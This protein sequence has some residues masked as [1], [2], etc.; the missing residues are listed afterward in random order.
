VDNGQGGRRVFWMSVYVIC[1][2][3]VVAWAWWELSLNPDNAL[4]VT[5]AGAR[6]AIRL[7]DGSSVELRESSRL[8]AVYRASQ[9]EVRLRS[10]E[11]LF[12]VVDDPSR[13][14]RVLT[15]NSVIQAGAAR[16]NVSHR[17]A[18]TLVTGIEGVLEV[19]Q[20]RLTLSRIDAAEQAQV[21]GP[22]SGQKVRITQGQVAHVGIETIPITVTFTGQ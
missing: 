6:K 1:A 21:G 8:R 9:R 4:Y 12:T 14:F 7:P 11:A 19:T 22:G 18:G 20:P 16:F 13:P 10:G 2:A 17:D 15:E 5:S 3:G